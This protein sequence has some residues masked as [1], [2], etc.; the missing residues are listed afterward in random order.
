MIQNNLSMK[1]CNSSNNCKIKSSKKPAVK[2]IPGVASAILP[3]AG[4]VL[5]G[6]GGKGFAMLST[7]GLV[8]AILKYSKNRSIVIQLQ[9]LAGANSA[10]V[11]KTLS[12]GE[13]FGRKFA[14]IVYMAVLFWSIYDAMQVANKSLLAKAKIADNKST[15]PDR[16]LKEEVIVHKKRYA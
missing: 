8:G 6:E 2:I 14:S 15:N 13:P 9:K 10:L 7:T 1:V 16:I 5:N 12:L 11:E 4:Q 3:G